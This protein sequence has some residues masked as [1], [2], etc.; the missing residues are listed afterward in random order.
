MIKKILFSLLLLTVVDS[1]NHGFAQGTDKK[2]VMIVASS[3]FRDEELILPKNALENAGIE[4]VLASSS[5]SPAR[6]M[7]GMEIKPDILIQD[8]KVED[9]DVVIFV[10]GA[11][12]KEY[13]DNSIAHRIAIQ[14]EHKDKVIGAICIAPVTLAKAGILEGRKA[15]VWPGAADELKSR[16]VHYT[17]KTVEIDKNIITADGPEAAEEFAKTL[18]S[19]FK[20]E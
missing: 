11:G 2:V 8:V 4:V 12:A 6:G 9:F 16:G 19:V 1:L 14:A 5:L 15:T 13:W 20:G 3:N 7:L 10:G 17:G 18:V